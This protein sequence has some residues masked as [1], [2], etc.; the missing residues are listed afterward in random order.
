MAEIDE[1]LQAAVDNIHNALIE[2]NSSIIG[3]L[4]GG[5]DFSRTAGRWVEYANQL[6]RLVPDYAAP[7]WLANAC[8]EF[9]AQ[10]SSRNHYQKL[11]EFTT[12]RAPEIH[13]PI[14][15]GD[16]ASLDV[17]DL[18]RSQSERFDLNGV[19][20]GLVSRL[21]ELIAADVIDNR[22]VHESLTRLH[23]LFR[24]TK[25][26]SFATV[27][28]TMNFGRFF[29]QSF[30]GLLRANKYAKPIVESFEK[31]FSEASAIVQQAEAATKQEMIARLT[32][33]ARMELFLDSHPDLKTTVAGFL[34]P[35]SDQNDE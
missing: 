25:N 8:K 1:D 21:A 6:L 14:L 7:R 5:G 30:G 35:P 13:Q 32:N 17:E 26:G 18:F 34:P 12:A 20:E 22:I 11:A 27:L 2:C 28:M 33:R 9:G 15:V 16:A 29:L 31:E 10:Y 4:A 23:A 19:F 3:S 24:R